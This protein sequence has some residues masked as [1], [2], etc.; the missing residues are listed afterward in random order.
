MTI[1]KKIDNNKV[2][3]SYNVGGDANGT[4]ALENVWQCLQKLNYTA[5]Q[6]LS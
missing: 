4:D 6:F 2:E 1:I 3:P 5:Q